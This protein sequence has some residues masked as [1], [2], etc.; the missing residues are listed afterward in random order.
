MQDLILGNTR[1]EKNMIFLTTLHD[2]VDEKGATNKHT[3]KAHIFQLIL[4]F[5]GGM[6]LYEK[7]S[8]AEELNL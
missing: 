8:K 4:S 5:I 3:K 1:H 2:E 6:M 7:E